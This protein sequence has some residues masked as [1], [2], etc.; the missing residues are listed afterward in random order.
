MKPIKRKL[1]GDEEGPYRKGPRQGAHGADGDMSME[2]VMALV[3]KSS[4]VFDATYHKELAEQAEQ[5]LMLKQPRTAS[6][7]GDGSSSSSSS[8]AFF[9]AAAAGGLTSSSSFVA[10]AAAA[11]AAAASSS[12][13]SSSSS[14]GSGLDDLVV[15]SSVGSYGHH[16]GH[17]SHSLSHAVS[18]PPIVA[19]PP[20]PTHAAA[21][22]MSEAGGG[23]GSG[24][25]GGGDHEATTSEES[26]TE[27][28]WQPRDGEGANDVVVLPLFKTDTFIPPQPLSLS[29]QV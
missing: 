11:A 2:D 12:S 27:D 19:L 29:Q 15:T 28:I 14:G 9:E 22:S 23:T 3:K 21:L 18:H 20:H 10:A 6:T 1:R 26:A 17:H 24:S 7:P 13:S 16:H 5:L 25:G 8:A 4:Y